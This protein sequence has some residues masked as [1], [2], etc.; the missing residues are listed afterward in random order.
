VTLLDKHRFKKDG[1]LRQT[2][3]PVFFNLNDE[4]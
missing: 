4:F 1:N 2:Q 3:T